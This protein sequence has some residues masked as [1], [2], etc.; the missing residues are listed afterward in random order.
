VTLR[1]TGSVV[2]LDDVRYGTNPATTGRCV[3][4]LGILAGAN[5]V[6][7]DNMMNNQVNSLS[8]ST[9]QANRRILDDTKDLILH[10]VVM[11]MNTSF[12]VQNFGTG[13]TTGNPCNAVQWGRGCL[14]LLGGLI[15]EA[16]GPVG[17]TAGTGYG[18][19]YT[20]DRCANL[21]PPPYFPTT[22][23]YLDNRYLEVDP[24][25][26]DIATLFARLS[27]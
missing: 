15:Q 7:A 5:V 3:D 21:R 2:V 23:R 11:A 8:G 9:T 16:R 25:G 24:V 27:P 19:Q 18:K 1:T 20:Y 10:A 6:V 12:R 13:P 26:F 17:T 14:M 22:G 4:V